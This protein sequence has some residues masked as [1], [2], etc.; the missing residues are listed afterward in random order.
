MNGIK[1]YPIIRQQRGE[2]K[3][4]FITDRLNKR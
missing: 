3:N 4:G 2:I 1:K